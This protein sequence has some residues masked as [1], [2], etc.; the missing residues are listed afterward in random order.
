MENDIFSH[1]LFI[2]DVLLLGEV[3]QCEVRSLN[4]ILKFYS[5]T[6]SMVINTD[7]SCLLFNKVSNEVITISGT[8][9]PYLI[10]YFF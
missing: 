4:R 3:Y 8:L 6:N 10:K 9:L 7:K 5:M 2:D 1:L